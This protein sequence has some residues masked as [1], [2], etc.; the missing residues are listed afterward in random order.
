MTP[1]MTKRDELAKEQGR[2]HA[3][4]VIR[5]MY[6]SKSRGEMAR[7]FAQLFALGFDAAIALKEKEIE[8]LRSAL[9][10]Y[11]N[12]GD[13]DSTFIEDCLERAMKDRADDKTTINLGGKYIAETARQALANGTGE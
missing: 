2:R 4:P 9:E 10:V 13:D 3:N 6:P 7:E 11:S 1:T 8:R 5:S 12:A